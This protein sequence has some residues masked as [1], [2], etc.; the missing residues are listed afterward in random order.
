MRMADGAPS[1]VMPL[2]EEPPVTVPDRM[3]ADA[4]SS[5]TGS[6]LKACHMRAG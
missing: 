2:R 4:W 3:S 1:A 5:P 6:A